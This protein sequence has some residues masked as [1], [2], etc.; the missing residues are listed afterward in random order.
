MKDFVDLR[1]KTCRCIDKIKRH[2]QVFIQPVLST[3]GCLP[4]ITLV[5]VN[6][7]VG[8]LNINLCKD[9]SATDTIHNFVN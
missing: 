6:A 4:L 5:Y 7:I 9:L 8:I 3:E 1:L 2:N